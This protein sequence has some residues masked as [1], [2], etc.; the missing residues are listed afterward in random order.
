MKVLCVGGCSAQL[1]VLRVPGAV[2]GE[3]ERDSGG[4]EEGAR[5]DPIPFCSGCQFLTLPSRSMLQCWT[6]FM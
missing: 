2:R 1:V 4:S 3:C 5:H 6:A